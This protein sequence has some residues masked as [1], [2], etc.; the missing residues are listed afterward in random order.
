M[1]FALCKWCQHARIVWTG[2]PKCA[3]VSPWSIEFG[4]CDW[5]VLPF[6]WCQIGGKSVC[7]RLHRQTDMSWITLKFRKCYNLHVQM[8]STHMFSIDFFSLDS[9]LCLLNVG[10]GCGCGN[11]SA[12]FQCKNTPTAG[13]VPDCPLLIYQPFVIYQLRNPGMV[14][15]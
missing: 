9:A 1:C 7:Q 4:L 13:D 11:S 10:Y 3:N 14:S 15:H 6:K 12:I 8:S 2:T 5:C